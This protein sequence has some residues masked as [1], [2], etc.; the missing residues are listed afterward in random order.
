MDQKT[1]DKLEQE[2]EQAIAGVVARL[3]LTKLPLLP[4]HQTMR[5]MANAAVAVYEAVA[6]EHGPE[7]GEP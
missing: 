7:D 1:V 4:S 5:V 2:I 3:G 6:H